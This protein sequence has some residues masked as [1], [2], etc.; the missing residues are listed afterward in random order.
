MADLQAIYNAYNEITD[1]EDKASEHLDA[2]TTIIAATQG[3]EGAK[4]LAAQFIPI[5]FKHFPTLHTKAIDG[6]FD[7]C[8]DDSSLIR[9]SAIKSLPS[10]CK[11][12]QQHTIK[13]ADVLCQL[14][15]LDDQDLVVVQVALQNLMIQSPR[16]VLAVVFRQGVKG[17]DLRERALDFITNQVMGSKETLFKDPEIELFFLGEM[18]KAMGSVSNSEL[19][20]FAKIIMQTKA[21]QSGKVDLTGLLNVYIQHITSEKPF[22]ISEQESVKRLLVAG[23]LSMPLFKRTISADPLLEFFAIHILPRNT[24]N[25][26]TDK[27]KTSVLRLYADSLITGHPSQTLMKSAGELLADLLVATVPVDQENAASIEFTQVEC[28]TNLM[29]YI[30][31]KNPE[32]I[33]KEE[34][35]SRF[36]SLYMITQSQI[37]N[38]KQALVVAQSTKPQG[39]EQAANIKNEFLKPKHLRSTKVVLNPSWKPLPESVKSKTTSVVVPSIKSSPNTPKSSVK[40]NTKAASR[41]V[42]TQQQQQQQVA[43]NKRK[44]EQDPNTKPKKP[45]IV[46]RHASNTGGNSPGSSS[47]GH[48]SK[49][50]QQQ[51]QPTTHPS[52]SSQSS[53]HGKKASGGSGRGL[54]NVPSAFDS[55][56]GRENSGRISFLKR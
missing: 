27:Q 20:T 5:F 40:T 52:Q 17:A 54:P 48:S 36:K 33:E 49:G 39:A 43:T 50:P 8:E 34:L 3:S 42:P 47:P 46:R 6:V 55:R 9:Q 26:L 29:Y 10:L 21:Y 24:F 7:L 41:P 37:S 14:L 15:Q 1:A 28:L 38:L 35:A 32:L 23:M 4:R 31:I 2:Y 18:Q 45:K 56:R 22:D 13:I 12:G 19:E 30:S 44:S 53:Q 11:D 51:L 25:K 16:E